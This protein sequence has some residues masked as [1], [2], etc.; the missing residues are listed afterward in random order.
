MRRLGLCLAL[1][2][3]TSAIAQ[4]RQPEQLQGVEGRPVIV[5]R[6]YESLREALRL[7]SAGVHRTN[8]PLVMR[9]VSCFADSGTQVVVTERGF[10]TATIVVVAGP[11]SGCRGSIP[12][13]DLARRR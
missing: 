12:I 13:E 2:V 8:Q 10:T 11:Q 6:D 3:T 4:E 1:L 5:F 7:I 9:L